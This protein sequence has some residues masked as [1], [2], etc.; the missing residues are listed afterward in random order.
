MALKLQRE[1]RPISA[2]VILAVLIAISLVV[3]VLYSR[4]DDAGPLHSLQ[5]AVSGLTAPV[6]TVGAA[7]G[8]GVEAIGEAVDNTLASDETYTQLKEQNQELREQ[9]SMYEEYYLEAQ[10]LEGLLNMRDAYDLETVGARVI[11][12]SSNAW[13][14]VIT[15]DSGSDDGVRSGL[16]VMGASGL[17][18]Q[19]I[20]TTANTA[21]VRLLADQQSGVSAFIQ[22]SRAEGIVRG[23]LEGMLYFEDFEL[24]AQ[25]AVGDV[26]I[27]SGMGGGFFRGLIIGTVAKIEQAQ[28]DT[29]RKVVVIPNAQSS[30]L[31][32]VLVVTAMN[33]EGAASAVFNAQAT[34][35]TGNGGASNGA[36]ASGEG[37]QEGA[38]VG[39]S[40]Q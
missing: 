33:S 39:G 14:Q 18:G 34:G 10:R 32:E 16:P 17:I 28:G 38:A 15:I 40:A 2:Q 22:S 12:K 13:H 19:T 6:K 5:N 1:R 26:V 4:E 23:S 35:L 3:L 9:L 25:M 31:E 36:A 20:S 27:T 21:D 29:T 37:S 11:G 8:A 30:S 7:G 24:D